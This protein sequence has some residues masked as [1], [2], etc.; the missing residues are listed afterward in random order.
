MISDEFCWWCTMMLLFTDRLN[1]CLGYSSIM[2]DTVH[3]SQDFCWSDP[4]WHYILISAFDL[5]WWR[6]RRE[7][8]RQKSWTSSQFC[9]QAV[10]HRRETETQ[11]RFLQVQ[12]SSCSSVPKKCCH[13]DRYPQFIPISGSPWW[14]PTHTNHNAIQATQPKR[15]PLT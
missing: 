2:I 15:K 14:P 5:R 4:S 8:S 10:C 7:S 11:R 3:S 13:Y 12:V 1:D 6:G 9:L